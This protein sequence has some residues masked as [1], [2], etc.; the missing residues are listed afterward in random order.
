MDTQ[1][2]RNLLPALV[3]GHIPSNVRNITYKIHDGLHRP[4]MLGFHIDPEPFVGTVIA[5]TSEAVI[6]K[7][8]RAEFAVLD[9]SLVSDLPDEG[10]KVS[11]TPYARRRF[12][13]MRA[14]TPEEK[15]EFLSDGTPYTTRSIIFGTAPAKLPIP[16]PECPELRELIRQLEELP[17]PDGH[18]KISHLLVDAGAKVSSWVDPS[19]ANIVKTPPAIS[20]TV[21]S[22][23]FQGTVSI[24]YDRGA[25]TYVLELHRRGEPI[26]RVDDVYFESL[27][28]VLERLI[29]DGSWRT[30]QVRP[31][32]GQKQVRH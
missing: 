9:R 24:S 16:D 6:V 13:G 32:T 11:V 2:I 27:G 25:D 14:D 22:K 19:P 23:M 7:T 17:A 12:D 10:S 4:S 1:A 31:L 15:T 28:E 30:I 20:F 21:E 29:D 5:I 3:R 8:G 26:E 18:R